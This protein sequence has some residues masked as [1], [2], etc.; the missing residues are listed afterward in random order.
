MFIMW[1]MTMN[2]INNAEIHI[3]TYMC[4]QVMK[5]CSASAQNIKSGL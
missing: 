2:N 4:Q 3:N 1:N 5:I